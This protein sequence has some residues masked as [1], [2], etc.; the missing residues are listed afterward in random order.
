M[1][2]KKTK[3][4]FNSF[5]VF[6]IL[7]FILLLIFINIIV[8]YITRAGYPI[9]GSTYVYN[10]LSALNFFNFKYNEKYWPPW[11]TPIFRAL[12]WLKIYKFF[13]YI[14][15]ILG[16]NNNNVYIGLK[17]VMFDCYK[18]RKIPINFDNEFDKY[19][20]KKQNEKE[21]VY[22]WVFFKII[23]YL[24]CFRIIITSICSLIWKLLITYTCAITI[25]N[26]ITICILSIIGYVPATP[27]NFIDS[28]NSVIKHL[29]KYLKVSFIYKILFRI[30]QGRVYSGN[31]FSGILRRYLTMGLDPWMMD[32][33]FNN[34]CLR[35]VCN[36]WRQSNDAPSGI[37]NWK[38]VKKMKYYFNQSLL[39]YYFRFFRI[40]C[41]IFAI[42]MFFNFS[43]GNV[44][45]IGFFKN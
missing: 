3:T 40:S 38:I 27:I 15:G 25:F 13:E 37:N 41:F 7:N 42:I 16:I 43:S 24:I 32:S 30:T 39:H 8:S 44:S 35:L 18:L 22:K 26:P 4:Y 6:K 9:Y 34:D 17:G 12:G 10:P 2:I 36:Q 28:K 14:Y 5:F 19:I 23:Y 20:K 29:G 45:S 1:K 31:Y 21:P 33:I 11:I